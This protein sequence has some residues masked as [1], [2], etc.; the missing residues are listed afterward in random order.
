MSKIPVRVTSF[1]E[2][3]ISIL[4]VQDKYCTYTSQ[5]EIT[6]QVCNYVKLLKPYYHDVCERVFL[7]RSAYS[8]SKNIMYKIDYVTE[9]K[10]NILCEEIV[11]DIKNACIITSEEINV[12]LI[13]YM[14]YHSF[15]LLADFL[16]TIDSKLP[17]FADYWEYAWS[18]IK[19]DIDIAFSASVRD[20]EIVYKINLPYKS[21]E[22][23]I[24]HRWVNISINKNVDPEEIKCVNTGSN[25]DISKISQHLDISRLKIR[26][27]KC[28][29]CFTIKKETPEAY[30]NN[31]VM[32][33]DKGLNNF[34]AYHFERFDGVSIHIDHCINNE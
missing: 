1:K 12:N 21:Q 5:D 26:D 4:S 2:Y 20:K 8:I 25:Q 13:R 24:W 14:I 31:N 10:N 29:L 27:N 23:V 33:V 19:N 3:H 16:K 30:N 22:K 9:H 15:E 17:S 6:N 18:I 32:S 7:A 28:Q 11:N 34:L